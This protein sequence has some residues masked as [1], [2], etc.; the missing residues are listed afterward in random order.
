MF[1]KRRWTRV[2]NNA[3]TN[4]GVSYGLN[5]RADIAWRN[6]DLLTDDSQGNPAIAIP[7]SGP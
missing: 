2:R 7:K 6:F 5:G 3:K 4:S 1:A